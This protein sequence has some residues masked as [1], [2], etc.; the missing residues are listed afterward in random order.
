[1][2][3]FSGDMCTDKKKRNCF[4]FL[5]D[6]SSI[7]FYFFLLSSS[8]ER[9]GDCIR[10]DEMERPTERVCN[11]RQPP[12]KY[13]QRQRPKTRH[14]PCKATLFQDDAQHERLAMCVLFLLS[15]GCTHVQPGQKSAMPLPPP[16]LALATQLQEARSES[17]KKHN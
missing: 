17:E 6:G 1:M 10:P 2:N 11:P 7:M 4:S 5:A 3:V 16:K 9:Q 14:A 8:R 15:S 12:F 13:G